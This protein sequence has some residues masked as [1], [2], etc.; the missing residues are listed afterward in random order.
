MKHKA[1]WALLSGLALTGAAHADDIGLATPLFE[2]EKQQSPA[3]FKPAP[4]T[5][6]TG[7]GT[8]TFENGAFP[9][10]ETAQAL[11]DQMDLQRATQ[12][13]MDFLPALSLYAIVKSQARDLQF[14]SASDVGVT[15]EFMNANQPYLTGNNST[16]Y[17]FSSLDL[18]MDGP[19]VVEIPKGM[20]GTANDAVFKYLADF[21]V[22]GPDK[23]EGGKY[24]F[25]PPDYKGEVPQG[26]FALK[27]NGKRIWIMMRGFGEVGTGD[28]ALKWFQDRLKVYPLG[29]ERKSRF[30]DASKV[31]MN[32]L[33]PEDFTAFDM[34]NEIIQYE[35]TS[36]FDAEQ[37]GRLRT[38]GIEKGKAFSPD[39][40]LKGILDQGAKQGAA[41]SRAIVYASRE[42]DIRY[43]PE[44]HWEKMFVRNT[45]FTWPGGATDIDARTLW[46]YQAIVVSPNLLSTTPGVGTSYLTSFRDQNGDFLDGAKSYKL[47][48]PANPPVKRFWAVTI[49]D[50]VTRALL[51]SDGA[52]T[53]GSLNKPKANDDGSVDIYVGQKAPD[54]FENNLITPDP[55]KGFFAVFR[56]YGPTEGYINKNWVLNDFELIP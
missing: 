9:N 30:V 34:L 48:V 29:K 2:Q 51:S 20:Y 44:S 39:K 27:S 35:P 18:G 43:W 56:F 8:L 33:P 17:A 25:L 46:H 53:V 41:M 11:F 21:G 16:I 22:T 1:I 45:E 19:T 6:E 26:Y 12:A 54:G 40:R 32:P 15:A 42:P 55:K 47:T 4:A 37:L 5:M 3:D 28:Q 31:K 23:G 14:T 10:K 7:F 38:L 50:P 52:I 24:L 36:L 49:Y 13:Y